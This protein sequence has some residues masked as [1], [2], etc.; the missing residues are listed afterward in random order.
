MLEYFV[1]DLAVQGVQLAGQ[2]A[3]QVVVHQAF[4]H[5]ETIAQGRTARMTARTG[6]QL[7]GGVFVFEV[8][9]EAGMQQVALFSRPL[10]V[11]GRRAMAGLAADAETVPLAVEAVF[12]RVEIALVAG[13]VAL[14][15]HEVGVLAGFAPVQR[16]L[17]VHAL[18]GVKVKPAVLL[19]IPGHAEGLQ[20]PLANLDQVLLQRGNAKGVGHLEVSRLAVA[21]GG[22]D[23]I[24]G[25]S[26]KKECGFA[27][28]GKACV[29]EVCR[30]R[31]RVGLLHRQLMVGAL[32]VL[33]LHLVATLALLF[34]NHL[35]RG[36]G[37]RFYCSHRCRQARCASLQEKPDPAHGQQQQ[38]NQYGVEV[39][40]G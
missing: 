24:L 2:Y 19:H 10:Q 32:P 29:I 17:E 31:L 7:D 8:Y 13:G 9:G 30:H 33:D 27:F 5:G 23:P 3:G 40:S 21:A 16:V 15:A 28:A 22:I 4:A 11:V 12:D 18:A 20:A 25:A 6:F 39:T 37:R 1:L 14:H 38:H 35:R 34:I 36:D 26:A